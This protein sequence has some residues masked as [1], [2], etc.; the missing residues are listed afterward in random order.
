[1]EPLK[2][3]GIYTIRV[4]KQAILVDTIIMKNLITSAGKQ[5]IAKRIGDLIDTAVVQYIS[6]GSGSTAATV[7]DTTMATEVYREF[8]ATITNATNVLTVETVIASTESNGVTFREI[9]IIGVDGT[10]TLNTGTLISRAIMSPE[11]A[12]DSG[13]VVTIKWELT[14]T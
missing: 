1:M 6:L 7:S 3:E 8:A 11:I 5:A 9:G 14:V 13:T 10:N 4:F 12:K 2:L